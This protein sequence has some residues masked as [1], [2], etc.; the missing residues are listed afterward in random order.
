MLPYSLTSRQQFIFDFNFGFFLRIVLNFVVWFRLFQQYL[1]SP[2]KGK[3][4]RRDDI[5]NF[6]KVSRTKKNIKDFLKK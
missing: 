6:E 1:F 5:L 2:K 4:K 3:I